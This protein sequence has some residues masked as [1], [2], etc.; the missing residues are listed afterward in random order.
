MAKFRKKPVV[1]EAIQWDG[2][3]K[4]W[5]DLVDMGC[6]PEQTIDMGKYQII[7]HHKDHLILLDKEDWVIKY[8][9]GTVHRYENEEFKEMWESVENATVS[10][11]TQ[12]SMI[13]PTTDS[14]GKKGYD[15]DSDVL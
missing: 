3:E 8:P 6:N 7:I 14:K 2:S 13:T 11:L 15:Q 5:N 4:A 10:E 9:D 1:I 12:F